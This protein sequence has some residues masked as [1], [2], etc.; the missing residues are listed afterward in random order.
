MRRKFLV[1]GMVTAGFA[2]AGF[3]SF[4]LMERHWNHV[5]RHLTEGMARDIAAIV[6]LYEASSGPEGMARL[7]GM[8]R[9]RFNMSVTVL[10][11]GS[12]PA[13]RPKPFFDLLDRALSEELRAS[14]RHPFWIDTVAQAGHL[15]VRIDLEQAILR[16]V[17]P[18]RQAYASNSHIFLVWMAGAWSIVLAVGYLL[19][20]PALRPA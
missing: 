3:L 4:A 20:R 10:P 6:D 7:I 8:G 18:R 11:A 17:V 19:L 5:A 2:L 12:L 9:D 14:I 13:P 1:L 15:E 16:F